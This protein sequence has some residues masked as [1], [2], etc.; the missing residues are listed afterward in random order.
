[1]RSSTGRKRL[2]ASARRLSGGASSVVPVLR[3][4]PPARVVTELVDELSADLVVVGASGRGQIV[5]EFLGSVSH[6]LATTLP[7][8]VL[9]VP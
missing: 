2:D 6:H 1:L 8:D 3:E 9:V 5:R 4:A 7:C